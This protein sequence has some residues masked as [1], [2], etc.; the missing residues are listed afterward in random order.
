MTLSCLNNEV[1]IH[2]FYISECIMLFWKILFWS[3]FCKI[4]Q[5]LY[6]ICIKFTQVRSRDPT[7]SNCL[8]NLKASL[9]DRLHSRRASDMS[10]ELKPAGQGP[11]THKLSWVWPTSLFFFIPLKV[12]THTSDCSSGR[13][14]SWL[15]HFTF[16]WARIWSRPRTRAIPTSKPRVLSCSGSNVQQLMLSP[17][18]KVAQCC[19]V[20]YAGTLN[21]I[22]DPNLEQGW[23]ARK[24]DLLPQA[25]IAPPP[26]KSVS[27]VNSVDNYPV[28]ADSF[29][30]YAHYVST[31]TDLS[32]VQYCSHS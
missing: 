1:I 30:I 9:C 18:Y 19:L 4:N 20:S 13:L 15:P 5:N 25:D 10:W 11:L 16:K 21:Y 23:S 22:V 27:E 24:T 29:T 28:S 3:C 31:S 26:S 7:A 2:I 32:A 14:H 6:K 12:S 8:S 17:T